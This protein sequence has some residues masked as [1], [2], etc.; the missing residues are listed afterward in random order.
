MT[1]TELKIAYLLYCERWNIKPLRCFHNSSSIRRTAQF[2]GIQQERDKRL[3][4]KLC[5]FAPFSRMDAN[6]DEA[7]AE[8]VLT[9]KPGM[10]NKIVD[11]IE[12]QQK[13]KLLGIEKKEPEGF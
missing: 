13:E 1:A 8:K 5:Y 4:P 10:I 9:P 12:R 11:I 7:P 2:L 3:P 6:V